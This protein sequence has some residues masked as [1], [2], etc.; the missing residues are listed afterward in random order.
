MKKKIRGIYNIKTKF[1]VYK[2]TGGLTHMFNGLSYAIKIAQRQKRILVID[3]ITSNGTLKGEFNKFFYI[4]LHNL[5]YTE[6]FSIIPKKYQYNGLSIEQIKNGFV[7]WTKE[8]SDNFHNYYLGNIIISDKKLIKK[9]RRKNLLIYA[10]SSRDNDTLLSIK[11]NPDIVKYIE[12][13]YKLDKKYIAVHYRNSDIINDIISFIEKIKEIIKETNIFTIYLATDDY[14]TYKII[15]NSI[16]NIELI[17]FTIPYIKISTPTPTG[18]NTHYSNPNKKQQTINYLIDMYFILKSDF[19]IPSKNS[20]MSRYA[21]MMRRKNINIFNKKFISNGEHSKKLI[22][23][24]R[25]V[26]DENTKIIFISLVLL[27]L[28][29]H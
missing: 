17:Q 28:Y 18:I 11:A 29:K 12:D 1:I 26:V 23:K 16:S 10:G 25:K 4:D 9:R 7:K 19:F 22:A 21:L 15:Q 14:K 6:D 8:A 13:N 20:G 3:T 24:V 2:A 5:N 27:C